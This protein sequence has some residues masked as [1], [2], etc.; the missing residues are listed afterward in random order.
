MNIRYEFPIKSIKYLGKKATLNDLVEFSSILQ[1]EV[2]SSSEI[3]GEV[4]CNR[5]KR[6]ITVNVITECEG[7]YDDIKETVD[8]E[9]NLLWKISLEKFE[10]EKKLEC[11]E[12]IDKILKIFFYFFQFKR[13][14]QN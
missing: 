7:S 8:D 12:Y 5:E 11:L 3:F 10:H 4:Q 6:L 13:K 14:D 9:I 2:K 1:E